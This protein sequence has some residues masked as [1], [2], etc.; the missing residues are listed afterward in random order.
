MST[1]DENTRLRVVIVGGGIT[2]LTLAQCLDHAGVDYILLEKHQDITAN[3]GGSIGLQANGCRILDQLGVYDRLLPW[4]NDSAFISNGFPDGFIR[5]YDSAPY[6]KML[7]YPFFIIRR[8]HLLR[9]LYESLKDQSRVKVGT[10]VTSITRNPSLPNGPLSI[11]TERG[12]QYTADIVVGADGIH[13]ISRGEMSRLAEP[14]NH[15]INIQKPISAKPNQTHGQ[16]PMAV[17][18]MCILGISTARDSISELI[19]REGVYCASYKH[20]F[21][22]IIPNGDGSVNWFTLIKLDK[23]YYYPHIPKWG[24]DEVKARLEALADYT[25]VGTL[26]FRAL[27]E[28]TAPISC[29]PIY[30]GIIDT[31]TMGRIVCIGDS[32]FKMSPYLAQAGNLCM[33]SAASLAN[34]LRKLNHLKR[35]PTEADI[36]SAL[37]E[38]TERMMTRLRRVNATSHRITRIMSLETWTGWVENRYVMQLTAAPLHYVN[39]AVLSAGVILDYLPLPQRGKDAEGRVARRVAMWKYRALMV[40]GVVFGVAVGALVISS[41][42]LFS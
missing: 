42:T 41:F 23:S 37:S 26:T 15:Q 4:L 33:E 3:F 29:V 19:K 13:G 30:E 31:P 6:E 18:Y 12:S 22:L 24:P 38:A 1:G 5:V 16:G 36:Q 10:K 2:G 32:V 17:E 8:T 39:M 9:G 35:L 34:N 20:V 7:G 25:L 28:I 40:C 21:W 14:Q 11:V 27:W